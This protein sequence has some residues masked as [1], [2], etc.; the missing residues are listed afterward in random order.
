MQNYNKSLK[1]SLLDAFAAS[2][3][4]YFSFLLRFEFDIPKEFSSLV[5]AWLPWFSLIQV[6]IFQISGLYNRMWRYTSLFDL[7]AILAAATTSAG[8]A[9]LA[10]FLL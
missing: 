5:L 1:L 3:A 8:I 2:L 4:L 9:F 10:I 6:V 7:Y